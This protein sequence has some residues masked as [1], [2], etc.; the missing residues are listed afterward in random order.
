MKYENEYL[1]ILKEEL[2]KAMGC[3][4]PIAVSYLAATL[5]DLLGV[6]PPRIDV[7]VSGNILKNVKSVVV[8]NTNGMRGIKSAIGIGI[9]AGRKDLKLECLS[10][11]TNDEIIKCQDYLKNTKINVYNKKDCFIFDISIVMYTKDDFV[12]G[13]IVD[14]HTNIVYLRKNDDIIINQS[15][16]N[17]KTVS[18]LTDHRVLN[19]ADIYDFAEKIEINK[20]EALI[21]DQIR[22]NMRIADV[23][24]K[25]KNGAN[26][27]KTILKSFPNDISTKAKAYAAAASDARM[28]GCELPV[29]INSG[30]GNQGITCSVPVIVYAEELNVSKEKLIRALVLSNLLTSHI[31]SGIGR[32]S[33]FCGVVAAGC[34]AGAAIA[35][36]YGGDLNM[37]SHTIVNSLAIVSGIICDGAKAS[38][39][40]KIASSVEAGIL[41]FKLYQEGNEFYSGEGIVTD[42]VDNTIK[43]VGILASQGMAETDKE[44]INLL[45]KDRN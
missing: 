36:L 21:T 29:V 42:G 19:V 37:I 33:A 44:I 2:Q 22:C 3:T 20:V 6:T 7:Y 16:E 41:G 9:I 32:L 23:G 25:N 26:I 45:L 38:C 5:K 40:A 13:R 1:S 27:G 30:S 10:K 12:E 31:K 11:V 4:E 15:L 43:N 14:N 17:K 8:P 39:A 24:L 18:N 35:Y 28:N 34:A